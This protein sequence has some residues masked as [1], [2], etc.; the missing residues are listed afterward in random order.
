MIKIVTDSSCD[1]PDEI[2]D[3]H[4]I[5]V[6]PL[7]IRFGSNEYVDRTEID[8]D[9]FWTRL[10]EGAELPETAAPSA[11]SFLDTYSRLVEDGADGIL[12]L[13]LSSE[14]SATYQAAVIAAER[15]TE[16]SS[17]P[18]RVLDSRAVSMGLGLQVI[19]AAEDAARD[20]ELEEMSIRA[21]A[22]PAFTTVI[23]ALDT[24]EFLKRGGRVGS[25]SA[26]IAGLLDVKPLITL[27]DGVI[28][29]A[30]RVRTRT[31][32]TQRIVD[33]CL[34][35]AGSGNLSIF[36]GRAPQLD[37]VIARIESETGASVIRAELGAV[38]G[39]HAGPGVLGMAHLAG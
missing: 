17:I 3:R 6:V 8:T 23:A 28:G 25:A 29:P 15:F 9:G 33:E 14:L 22:R 31:K 18:V 34:A 16:T 30:G 35:R 7:T 21:M 11:G 2:V 19:A 12:A 5:S 4:D 1:L 32:A 24:V 37:D 38:V 13:C 26:L 10:E 39:T 20:L 36:G 27:A